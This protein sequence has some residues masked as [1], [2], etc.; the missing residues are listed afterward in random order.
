MCCIF[1]K[2]DTDETKVSVITLQT[3]FIGNTKIEVTL[4]KKVVIRTLYI[5]SIDILLACKTY[6][7]AAAVLNYIII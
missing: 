7:M 3:K 6:F 5:A 2:L 4:S 1:L